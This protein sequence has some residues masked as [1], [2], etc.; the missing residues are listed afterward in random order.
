MGPDEPE[1][2]GVLILLSP[3]SGNAKPL[4]KEPDKHEHFADF[5]SLDREVSGTRLIG[6]GA[7]HAGAQSAD[8]VLASI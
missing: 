1:A 8:F 3:T 7:R 5:A 4:D 2:R 6:G